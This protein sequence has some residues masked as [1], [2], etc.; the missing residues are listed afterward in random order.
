LQDKATAATIAYTSNYQYDQV[1]NVKS[2]A[3]ATGTTQD[4]VECFGY[5]YLR[6][7]TD[8]WTEGA[9]ATCTNPAKPIAGVDPYRLQWTFDTLGNR[10]T[11]TSYAADGTTPA[12]IATSEYAAP[13]HLHALSKV[14]VTLAGA[15]VK[16]YD[17]YADGATK[18]RPGPG[19]GQQTLFWDEEGHLQKVTDG[20]ADTTFLYTTDGARLIRTD[21]GSWKTLTLPD[22][23]E[24]KRNSAGTIAATR[25]YSGIAVRTANT[26]A[27]GNNP[28]TLSDPT[29]QNAKDAGLAGRTLGPTRVNIA[30]F[31]GYP[32]C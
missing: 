1:G 18:S 16:N 23:T 28:I 5:D 26:D 25:Y 6:R 27:S 3:T 14:T 17:Y 15:V 2:I 12:S 22:G 30:G 7:L 24:L 19:L 13:G 31:G 32:H 11:Q 8:A 4:Q 20:G 10:L 29:G 21:P 9:T